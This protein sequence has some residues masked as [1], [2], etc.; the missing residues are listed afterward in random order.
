MN[1][2]RVNVISND[3]A[4]LFLEL[5]QKAR[6]SLKQTLKSSGHHEKKIILWATLFQE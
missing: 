5:T 3:G 4:C 1:R 2:E 6:N